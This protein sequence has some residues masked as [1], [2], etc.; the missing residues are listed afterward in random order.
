MISD[1]LFRAKNVA[2]RKK[3]VGLVEQA[4]KAGVK[5]VIFSSMNPSGERLD[6]LSGVAG[7]LRFPLP[8]ID[9]IE[10]EEYK[11]EEEEY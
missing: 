9:D 8:G 5:S 4:E 6:N 10:E 7:I 1:K 2:T 3:Y 11:E